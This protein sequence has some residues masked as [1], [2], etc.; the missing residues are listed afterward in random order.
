MM[1]RQRTSAG[2]P[3]FFHPTYYLRRPRRLLLL[4][5]FVVCT[6]YFL[7]DRHN[8]VIHHEVSVEGDVGKS[9]G[10]SENQA[11]GKISGKLFEQ[12]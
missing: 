10:E 1:A 9:G 2:L 12:F 8:L 11:M 3:Q 5:A 4:F 7:W 6:T